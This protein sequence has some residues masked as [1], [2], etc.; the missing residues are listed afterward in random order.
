M[1]TRFAVSDVKVEV[2]K[3]QSSPP[4][5]AKPA[6]GGDEKPAK[7]DYLTVDGVSIDYGV[8][9]TSKNVERNQMTVT[10][11]ASGNLALYEVRV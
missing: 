11:V 3:I 4:P 10:S 7:M 5:Q 2:E 6:N 8:T 9:D 1:S